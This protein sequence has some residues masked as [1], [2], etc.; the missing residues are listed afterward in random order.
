MRGRTE[1]REWGP[2]YPSL[3]H[4]QCW[5][6]ARDRGRHAAFIHLLSE[7]HLQGERDHH[8][9][10]LW[11]Q[12]LVSTR[13]KAEYHLL[14]CVMTLLPGIFSCF[15]TVG[16]NCSRCLT[17]P[18]CANPA[19]KYGLTVFTTVQLV[20]NQFFILFGPLWQSI[21][22]YLKFTV[23]TFPLFL[24]SMA[25]FVVN[26]R[27]TVRV[28][29]AIRNALCSSITWNPRRIWAL[30]HD[31]VAA[32]TKSLRGTRADRTRTSRWT[33]MGPRGKRSMTANR[34]NSLLSGSPYL[35]IRYDR[36][37]QCCQW[38]QSHTYLQKFK[39]KS[40]HLSSSMKGTARF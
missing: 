20:K 36:P 39:W 9:L 17:V 14:P 11:L 28:W 23:H 16:P 22:H 19:Q 30:A 38:N 33:V 26:I 15:S 34:E 13:A 8:W 37:A 6:A 25:C 12:Q 27:W 40:T 35:T 21:K 29:K 32:R 5:G 3:L 31:G 10:W 2:V 4:P 18:P 1:L 7:V 24:F